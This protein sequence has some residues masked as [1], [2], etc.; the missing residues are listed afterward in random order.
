MNLDWKI[1]N[2]NFDNIFNS[3]ITIFI[4]STQEN[5]PFIMYTAMDSNMED[6]VKK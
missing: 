3:M 5:W 6:Y 2:T 1:F 4:I